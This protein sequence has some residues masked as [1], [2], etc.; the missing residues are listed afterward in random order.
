MKFKSKQISDGDGKKTV[1][2]SLNVAQLKIMFNAVLMDSISD[3]EP[4]P[5]K[6]A[7]LERLEKLIG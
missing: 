7:L 3:G 6:I 2:A 1:F 5:A 4:D